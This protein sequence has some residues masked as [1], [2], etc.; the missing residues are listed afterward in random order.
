MISG[1]NWRRRYEMG[2]TPLPYC[3]SN[4]AVRRS[5]DNAILGA[6][7]TD[8]VSV[9][10]ATIPGIGP[11]VASCLSSSIPDAGLFQSSREFA[12]YLSLVPRQ[13]SSGGKPRLGSISKMGDGYLRTLLVVG[14]TAVIRYARTTTAAGTTWISSLLSK[15][16]VRLVSVALANKTARIAWA[17][18]ARG[19][20]DRRPVRTAA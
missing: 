1:G 4:R 12:A 19:D 20:V 13:H 7:R 9:R 18:L 11:I 2:C 14:A 16:P 8:P 10:L 15:K 17:L 6:H 5:R 3:I